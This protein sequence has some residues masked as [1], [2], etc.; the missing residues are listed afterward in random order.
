MN[1]KMAKMLRKTNG[2]VTKKVKRNFLSLNA[3]KRSK[4]RQE[5]KTKFKH[6]SH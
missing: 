3:A 6:V 2:E 4:V 5:Y 1:Q